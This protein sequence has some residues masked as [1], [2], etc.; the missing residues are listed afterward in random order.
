MVEFKLLLEEAKFY[1]SSCSESTVSNQIL[2]DRRI[3]EFFLFIQ[4]TDSVPD[5][6]S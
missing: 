4:D 1:A 6:A 3:V 2:E 5:P